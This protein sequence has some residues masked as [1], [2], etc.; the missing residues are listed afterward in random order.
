MF[1]GCGVGEALPL[2]SDTCSQERPTALV[3]DMT[4]AHF[5]WSLVRNVQGPQQV[6]V[7]CCGLTVAMLC[8]P[9]A[10]WF[11]ILPLSWSF[12]LPKR[13]PSKHLLAPV[14]EFLSSSNLICHDL[15]PSSLLRLVLFS[16]HILT[17]AV[18]CFPPWMIF[19][20][21][22]EHFF[23]LTSCGTE[24]NSPRSVTCSGTLKTLTGKFLMDNPEIGMF[25]SKDQPWP[26]NQLCQSRG[27]K[28]FTALP[29]G[30][31]KEPVT[32]QTHLVPD[33]SR[34][35]CQGT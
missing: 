30:Q 23:L 29:P 32:V 13:R 34:V 25:L 15:L 27:R 9:F 4:G 28:Y 8:L 24:N 11:W 3:R 21:F 19:Y 2:T 6:L 31:W 5:P 12:F 22:Q 10:L 7:C 1:V 20:C 17:K 16:V 18:S 33:W 26:W 14:S 35:L